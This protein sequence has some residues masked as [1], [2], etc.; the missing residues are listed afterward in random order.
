MTEGE[1]E[2]VRMEEAE[3][4]E[5]GEGSLLLS[6]GGGP[7]SRPAADDG[8]ETEIVFLDSSHSLASQLTCSELENEV[9]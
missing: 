9:K 8:E 5:E 4:R 3:E 1:S 7:C 2:A 6:P